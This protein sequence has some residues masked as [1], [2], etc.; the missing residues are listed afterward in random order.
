[1]T[2][3]STTDTVAVSHSAKHRHPNVVVEVQSQNTGRVNATPSTL[4]FTP[5]NFNVPQNVTLQAVNDSVANSDITATIRLSVQAGSDAAF[6]N[7][8]PSDIT[9]SVNDDDFLSRPGITTGFAKTTDQ[10]PTITWSAVTGAD[11]YDLWLSPAGDTA[12]PILNVNVFGTL[13]TPPTNLGIGPLRYVGPCSLSI[14]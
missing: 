2:E 6:E 14:R 9:V 8:V 11:S 4:T 1:M 10:Q 3:G 12:N 5:T 13:F 7:A